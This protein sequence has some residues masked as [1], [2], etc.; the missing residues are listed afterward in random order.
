MEWEPFTFLPHILKQIQQLHESISIRIIH[1]IFPINTL[2]N[3]IAKTFDHIKSIKQ[4][5]NE[6]F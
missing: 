2:S 6:F 4:R 5:C 3:E 1:S